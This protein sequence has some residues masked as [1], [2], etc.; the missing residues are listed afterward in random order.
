MKKNFIKFKRTLFLAGLIASISNFSAFAMKKENNNSNY[1]NFLRNINMFN[2][3]IFNNNNTSLNYQNQINNNLNN[4]NQ[5]NNNLNNQNR[6]NNS[7]NN[8]NQ[9]NNFMFNNNQLTE[10]EKI[11]KFDDFIRNFKDDDNPFKPINTFAISEYIYSSPMNNELTTFK[12]FVGQ[13]LLNTTVNSLYET[14]KRLV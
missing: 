1:E 14:K 6:I 5:I 12:E 7:L 9:I 3:S 2:T 10:E 11:K 13:Q 8:Q 4:Q